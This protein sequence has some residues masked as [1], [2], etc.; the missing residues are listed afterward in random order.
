MSSMNDDKIMKWFFDHFGYFFLGVF[1]L[2]IAFWIGAA[3]L[4]GKALNAVSEH[5]LKAVVER[6]WNGETKP[7]EPQQ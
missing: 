1:A 6:I 7:E 4:A 5:G 3:L 2:A